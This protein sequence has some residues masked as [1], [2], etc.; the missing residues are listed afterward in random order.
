MYHVLVISLCH[1]DPNLIEKSLDQLQATRDKTNVQMDIVMV[2]QHWPIDKENT[3]LRLK[4]IAA[5]NNAKLLDF[6]KNLGLHKGFNAAFLSQNFPDNGMVIGYDPDTWPVT[7]GWD[8]AMCDTFVSDPSIGWLSLWNESSDREIIEQQK[9]L[10]TAVIGGHTVH[11]LDYAVMNSICGFRSG[12]LK[13]VGGLVEPNEFYGGVECAMW[14]HLQEHKMK[15]VF[16]RDFKEIPELRW[17]APRAYIVWKDL[18]GREGTVKVS[19]EDW[20]KTNP[21]FT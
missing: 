11:V 5:K 7:Y 6:G 4:E 15:W 9:G 21:I 17:R 12:W 16:M 13:K 2:D 14:N 20:L 19:F 3:H 1:N 8:K 18:H 10:K